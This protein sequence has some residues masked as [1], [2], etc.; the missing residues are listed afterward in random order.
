M[1]AQRQQERVEV[2]QSLEMKAGV[3]ESLGQLD[4]A[5]LR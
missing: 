5:I 3:Q 2:G 1:N 4:A